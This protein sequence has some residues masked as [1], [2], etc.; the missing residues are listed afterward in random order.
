MTPVLPRQEPFSI[1]EG[2]SRKFNEGAMPTALKVV[3]L[4]G[5]L[6]A[7]ITSFFFLP[8][9]GALFTS[10]VL[11]ACVLIV[12]S[13]DA[14]LGGWIQ[15]VR[16]WIPVFG[17]NAH[18]VHQPGIRVGVGQGHRR[19]PVQVILTPQNPRPVQVNRV[20]VLPASPVRPKLRPVQQELR[21][22]VAGGHQAGGSVPQSA[23]R[24]FQNPQRALPCGFSD[25]QQGLD[26]PGQAT[27]QLAARRGVSR[28]HQENARPSHRRSGSIIP[29]SPNEA[30]K[31]RV[32]VGRG[33]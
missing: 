25:L 18:P 26:A 14:T 10:V 16:G 21:V 23:P 5:A 20:Q 8:L 19:P 9:E 31:K 33:N 17:R 1:I 13:E 12:Q 3:Q 2:P 11:A 7:S 6:I 4:A 24:S 28:G 32:A 27:P 30:P 22:R 29:L 15:T